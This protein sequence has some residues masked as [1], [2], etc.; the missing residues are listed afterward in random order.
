MQKRAPLYLAGVALIVP[1]VLP[2]L[3]WTYAKKSPELNGIPFFYWYQFVLVIVSVVFTSIAYAL[4]TN[5]D[6]ERRASEKS[7]RETGDHA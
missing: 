4:V 6:R 3:V 2:L 5:H 1:I 7:Q